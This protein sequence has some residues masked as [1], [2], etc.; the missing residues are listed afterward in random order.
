MPRFFLGINE[1]SDDNTDFQ[2]GFPALDYGGDTVEKPKG[3]QKQN[4]GESKASP[5]ELWG[6]LLRAPEKLS[7]DLVDIPIYI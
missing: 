2:R 3:Y 4:R 6:R 1:G 5:G 7:A